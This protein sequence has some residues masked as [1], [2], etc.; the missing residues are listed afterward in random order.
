MRAALAQR[1]KGDNMETSAGI[2]PYT[3]LSRMQHRSDGTTAWNDA[4]SEF[5]RR[6]GPLMFRWCLQMGLTGGADDVVQELLIKLG[7]NLQK[8]KR[9]KGKFRSWLYVVLKHTVCD[10]FAEE[11]KRRLRL[12]EYQERMA[13]NAAIKELEHLFAQDH[14]RELAASILRE[15]KAQSP[16]QEWDAFHLTQEQGKSAAEAARLLAISVN[17]VFTYRKRVKQRIQNVRKQVEEG[18]DCLDSEDSPWE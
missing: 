5:V 10:L 13:S 1:H 14:R 7:S 2:T 9:E 11:N 15:V 6:F 3:L 16:G 18:E 17:T 8:H 12:V 4:W